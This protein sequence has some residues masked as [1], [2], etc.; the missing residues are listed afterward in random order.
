MRIKTILVYL[1]RHHG[2]EELL[3][4]ACALA[5]T[6]E[7]HLIGVGAFSATPPVPPLAIPYSTTVVEE[8]M[9]AAQ[10]AEAKL[11]AAF[12]N[13]TRE[14]PFVAEWVNMRVLAGDLVRAVL[15]HARAVDLIVASQRDPDWEL[16][17]VLDFPERLALESGRPVFLVPRKGPPPLEIKKIAVAWNGSRESAR[18]AF[19]AFPF[20]TSAQSV[21]ILTVTSDGAPLAEGTPATALAETLARHDIPTTLT[22]LQM[23]NAGVSRTLINEATRLEADLLVSGAYGHSRLR[24]FVFGGVTR[25]LTNDSPLPLLLSH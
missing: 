20:Y 7:A 16:G 1:S 21:T 14:A 8:M 3:D 23:A 6:H 25:D 4:V 10:D 15:D 24:E 17:T 13:A 19:D 9:R 5:R 22:H 2:C 12:E 11:K 18:A